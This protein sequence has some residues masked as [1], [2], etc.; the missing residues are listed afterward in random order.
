MHVLYNDI[1]ICLILRGNLV[2]IVS[3]CNVHPLLHEVVQLYNDILLI[4]L[5]LCGNLVTAVVSTCNTHP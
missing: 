5:C 4:F 3:T 2:I 1:L